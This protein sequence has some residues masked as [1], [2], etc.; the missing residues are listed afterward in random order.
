MGREAVTLQEERFEGKGGE[1][2]RSMIV[3]LDQI[4]S[5]ERDLVFCFFTDGH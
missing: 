5:L 4:T 2:L 1:K 3:Y